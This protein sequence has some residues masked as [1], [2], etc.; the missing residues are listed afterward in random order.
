M[1]DVG[2]GY[3]ALGREFRRQGCVVWG[4]ERDRTAAAVASE[5]LDRVI[6]GDITDTDMLHR[7]LNG[8]Q[9]DIIVFSDVL[10]HMPD[11]SAVVRLI[12]QYLKPG[13]KV[14]ISVPNVANW[15]T[16]MS[17][18]FGRFTYQDSGVLDRTY[19]RFFTRR[20][21]LDFI[22]AC[23]LQIESVDYTPMLTRVLLPIIK[24]RLPA[25][26]NQK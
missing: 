25:G 5:G 20:S 13:G 6:K 9:F 24:R 18:L 14:I 26:E 3:G 17:L 19:L 2:C 22:R 23:G 16:R 10:E 12:S 15:Y 4:I 7:E 11:P 21:A 8:C 1:L